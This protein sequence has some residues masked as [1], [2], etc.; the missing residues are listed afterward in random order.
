[1][2][3]KTI[4]GEIKIEFYANLK[5]IQDLYFDK[6]LRVYKIL[7]EKIKETHNLKMSY[8]MF[9][10]YAKKELN[11]TTKN[12]SINENVATPIIEQVETPKKEEHEPIIARPVFAKAKKFNPHTTDLKDDQIIGNK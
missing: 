3:N 6:G 8:K 10:Y 11:S 2:K 4:K 5:E 7:Y 12:L 9:C 1:M